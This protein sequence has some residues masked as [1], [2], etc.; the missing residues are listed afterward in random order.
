MVY[1]EE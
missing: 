1:V